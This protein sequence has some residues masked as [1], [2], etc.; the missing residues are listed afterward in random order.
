MFEALVSELTQSVCASFPTISDSISESR[1]SF[2]VT[3]TDTSDSRVT[4]GEPSSTVVGLEPIGIRWTIL[5][6]GPYLS[7]LSF[8]SVSPLL[9]NICCTNKV[10]QG[11]VQNHP[12]HTL[13]CSILPFCSHFD[14]SVFCFPAVVLISFTSEG[15]TV[16]EDVGTTQ[17]CLRLSSPL[18]DTLT[19]PLSFNNPATASTGI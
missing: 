10:A 13:N 7:S 16:S 3:L 12:Q 9:K 8:L 5:V 1:E 19:V 11:E 17:V 4:I 2:R 6:G 18:T 15:F 14:P